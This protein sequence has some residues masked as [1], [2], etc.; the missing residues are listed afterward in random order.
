MHTYIYTWD[1]LWV[2]NKNTTQISQYLLLYNVHHTSDK[3]KS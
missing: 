3:S 1:G 2:P